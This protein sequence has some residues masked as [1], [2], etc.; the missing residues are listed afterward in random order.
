ML[1]GW[2][3]WDS[4]TSGPKPS[5]LWDVS[6]SYPLPCPPGADFG[7]GTAEVV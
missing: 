7:P 3:W 1:L 2:G 4:L 6:P 5:P